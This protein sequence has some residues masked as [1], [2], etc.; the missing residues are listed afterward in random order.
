MREIDLDYMEEHFDEVMDKVENG[1]SFL[2]RTPDG[3]GIIILPEKNE[4][5][6]QME[7]KGLIKKFK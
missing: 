3:A 2:L 4:V 5:I 1:E 7:G 6:Q